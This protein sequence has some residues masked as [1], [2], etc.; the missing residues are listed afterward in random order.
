MSIKEKIGEGFFGILSIISLLLGL[1]IYVWT[2]VLAFS[3][4][5]TIA[6]ILTLILPVLSTIYWFFIVGTNIGFNTIFCLAIIIY[7]VVVGIMLL[8]SALIKD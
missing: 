3:M 2:I 4:S 5:G 6:A 7:V 8:F 1:V